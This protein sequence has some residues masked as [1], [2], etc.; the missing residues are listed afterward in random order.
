MNKTKILFLVGIWIAILPYLGFPY[1]WRNIFF[2]LSGLGLALFSYMIHREERMH[3]IGEETGPVFDNFSENRDF[4]EEAPREEI[5]EVRREVREEIREEV[6]EET[7]VVIQT[8]KPT[9]RRKVI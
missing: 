5:R 2:T 8:A 9:R 3:T 1:Y 7:P 6:K 4:I